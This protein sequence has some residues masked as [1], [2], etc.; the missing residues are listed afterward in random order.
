MRPGRTAAVRREHVLHGTFE[1][2][3]QALDDLLARHLLVEP[4]R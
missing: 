1:Q 2:R 3:T 4:A